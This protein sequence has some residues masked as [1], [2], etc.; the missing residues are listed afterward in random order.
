MYWITTMLYD[1]SQFGEV[2]IQSS[3]SMPQRGKS[4]SQLTCL[5][6]RSYYNL[7][8]TNRPDIPE[9]FACL[10]ILKALSMNL[11]LYLANTSPFKGHTAS[12]ERTLQYH[13][14]CIMLRRTTHRSRSFVINMTYF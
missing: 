14:L 6:R 12:R 9:Y 4:I 2:K 11:L 13:G 7:L 3:Q 1:R 8:A 5:G 10:L